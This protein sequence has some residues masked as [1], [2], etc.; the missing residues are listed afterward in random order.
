MNSLHNAV[1]SNQTPLP[2]LDGIPATAIA[3][4]QT[5][6]ASRLP[7]QSGLPAHM[8]ELDGVRGIAIL[9]VFLF[10]LGVP[11]IP[12]AAGGV[13]L[14]FVLSGFLIT[15][16]LLDAKGL[17]SSWRYL[18]VFYVRRILRIFP[19]YYLC[20]TATLIIG[21]AGEWKVGDWPYYFTYTQ[22]LVLNWAKGG[23]NAAFPEFLNHTWSLAVEE[24]FYLVWPIIVLL[25]SKSVLTVVCYGLVAA[26]PVFRIIVT[27]LYPHSVYDYTLLPSNLDA[28]GVGSLLALALR[29]RISRTFIQANIVWIG[30]LLAVGTLS[31]GTLVGAPYR[32]KR[33]LV[34]LPFAALIAGAAIRP[35]HFFGTVLRWGWLRYVGKISYGLYLYHMIVFYFVQAAVWRLAPTHSESLWV[36]LMQAGLAV[37]AAVMSWQL[38]EMPV[39]GLKRHFHYRPEKP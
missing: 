25:C 13:A 35:Q 18:G 29:D 28:L 19:I 22:N 36:R 32:I 5:D 26:S 3:S 14:F 30:V 33:V 39:N 16:L 24:Q 6:Y 15:G 31:A 27:Q 34:L 7:P 9:W 20:I 17:C 21:L 37:A 38:L 11:C 23:Q 4:N 2:E 12:H 8:P 1:A 10:H